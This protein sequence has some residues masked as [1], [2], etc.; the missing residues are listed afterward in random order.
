MTPFLQH[1]E[2]K[3]NLVL[4]NAI[5]KP[6]LML[7]LACTFYSSFAQGPSWVSGTAYPTSPDKQED[8][9]FVLATS[10][11][12]SLLVGSFEYGIGDWDGRI[13]KL[14]SNGT[15]AW[16]LK[17]GAAG[18]D[19]LHSACEFSDG[20][21]VVGRKTVNGNFRMWALKYSLTGTLI[22]D[23][24]YTS[25]YAGNSFGG[26]TV[27]K[28][29]GNRAII[30]GYRSGFT[31]PQTEPWETFFET[32]QVKVQYRMADCDDNKNDVHTTQY[33]MRIIN[34]T[35]KKINITYVLGEGDKSSDNAT[36]AEREY[37]CSLILMP[38]EILEAKCPHPDRRLSICIARRGLSDQPI[39]SKFI[40]SKIH[41]YE[42]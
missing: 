11:G 29:L 32:P 37:Y 21:I 23:Q 30:G 33:L 13:V 41:V 20:Y 12:G 8:S 16:E 36:W 17:P 26:M 15:K 7:L 18:L 38:G 28:S 10:D 19:Y 9:E 27:I 31:V 2:I 40:I 39:K 22:W 4:P 14:N 34:S 3:S 35:S 25:N 24:T 1:P 42:L 5:I 6:F